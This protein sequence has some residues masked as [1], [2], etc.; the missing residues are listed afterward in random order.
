MMVRAVGDADFF[1]FAQN[2][3]LR[4]SLRLVT[5]DRGMAL[6]SLVTFEE[7]LRKVQAGEGEY[8]SNAVHYASCCYEWLEIL[9]TSTGISEGVGN[10]FIHLSYEC[11][12]CLAK[13]N[14]K[15]LLLK[16]THMDA[17]LE[18]IEFIDGYMQEEQ[19]SR[20]TKLK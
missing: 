13:I 18:Q 12:A 16:S 17:L 20:L 2:Y 7:S 5:I 1:Q 8:I 14:I 19:D 4:T 9:H 11:L 15:D 10:K 6:E 3:N